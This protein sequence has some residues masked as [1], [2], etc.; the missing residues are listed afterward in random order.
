[1]ANVKNIDVAKSELEEETS[2]LRQFAVKSHCWGRITGKVT[3][4]L[5]LVQTR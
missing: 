5:Q 4:Q 1:M 3:V 2:S